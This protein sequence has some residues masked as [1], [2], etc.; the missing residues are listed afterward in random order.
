[1]DNAGLMLPQVNKKA[2]MN[3]ALQIEVYAFPI[4]APDFEMI[5]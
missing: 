5:T 1:M 3:L 2:A 4:I